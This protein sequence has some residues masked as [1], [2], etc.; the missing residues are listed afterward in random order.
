ME[1]EEVLRPEVRVFKLNGDI[2]GDA[3]SRKLYPTLLSSPFATAIRPTVVRPHSHLTPV[4]M[5]SHPF[6]S[7]L[8]Q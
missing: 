5:V 6:C 2:G 7:T 8:A 3:T 4:K 1:S